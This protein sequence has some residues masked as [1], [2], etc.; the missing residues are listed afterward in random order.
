M[1]KMIKEMSPLLMQLSNLFNIPPAQPFNLTTFQLYNIP[2]LQHS[3]IPTIITTFVLMKTS[4]KI[5]LV[6]VIFGLTIVSVAPAFAQCAQCAA[7]V[8]TNSASGASTANGLNNG[9]IFL[10]CAPYLAVALGGYIWYKNYKRKNVNLEV[11]SEK[12]HLN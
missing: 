10:L 1:L 3:N 2:T 12:L 7:A 6:L 8:K 9:I 4:L 5:S 11:P